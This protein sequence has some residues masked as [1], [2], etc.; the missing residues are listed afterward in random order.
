MRFLLAAL[1]ALQA[2]ASAVAA[3]VAEMPA[4]GR[5]TPTLA[6]PALAPMSPAMSP[7]LVA[8]TL[9]A[10]LSPT[11]SAPAALFAA[12]PAANAAAAAAAAEPMGVPAAALAAEGEARAPAAMTNLRAV[13]A[14]VSDPKNDEAALGAA[15]D[16]SRAAAH[17]ETAPRVA[18]AARAP[19]LKPAAKTARWRA[20]VP[21]ALTM[22]NMASGLAGAFLASTGNY[23]PAAL[24]ILAGNLF[25]ALDGRAARALKVDNPLGIDLDS[26]ADVVTFG[27]APA[28]LV[29]KAALLPTLGWWGFPIAAAFAAGGLYRLARFNVG[30]HAEKSGAIPP[31]K[32]DSFTGLPI[33]GGAGVIVALTLGLS[34]LPA[35]AVAP[36]AAA[37][38]VLAAAAMVSRL[39]YP[40]F[41]K[42]GLKLAAAAGLAAA[43]VPAAF[44]LYALIPAAVFG[45]YLATGPVIALTRAH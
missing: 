40:A 20:A 41:K 11:L 35:A 5:L 36:A 24:A 19:A 17:D 6:A 1:I 23:V 39:P 42:K 16:L 25:D 43:V 12:A 26:L 18:E 34:A 33:P 8:P 21:N 22:A 29:F 44:G 14:A 15:F 45:L 13:G 30:A 37:V 2:P 4:I 28:L 38:T 31:K 10:A 9:S 27:A 32:S 3:V 7:A